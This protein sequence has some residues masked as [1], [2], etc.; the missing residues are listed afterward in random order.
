[1]SNYNFSIDLNEDD[2][3]HQSFE[4]T[5]LQTK[6]QEKEYKDYVLQYYDPTSIKIPTDYINMLSCIYDIINY[7]MDSEPWSLLKY[8]EKKK[9]EQ[10]EKYIPIKLVDESKFPKIDVESLNSKIIS[11]DLLGAYFSC[12]DHNKPIILLCPSRILSVAKLCDIKAKLLCKKV[13]IHE[14]AH[15]LMDPTNWKSEKD[16]A[17]Q[18]KN[19]CQKI[20]S[21][22]DRFME[23]SLA[24]MLTLKYFHEVATEEFDPVEDFIA[25]RQPAIYQFG[26][27]QF[28]LKTNWTKWRDYKANKTSDFW[29]YWAGLF[30]GKK[31][32]RIQGLRDYKNSSNKVLLTSSQQMFLTKGNLQK[33]VDMDSSESPAGAPNWEDF[34][35]ACKK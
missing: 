18:Q 16:F 11:P 15:A 6:S 22:A 24:N 30:A 9:F 31:L 12:D 29:S 26:I 33:E 34:V 32:D 7:P 19:Q 17:P 21:D 27:T 20:I 28:E 14:F 1:M 25:K 5:Q 35:E 4:K 3:Q 23:E 8:L 2:N 10:S 13:I